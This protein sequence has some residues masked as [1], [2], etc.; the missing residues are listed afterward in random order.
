MATLDQYNHWRDRLIALLDKASKATTKISPKRADLYATL[1]DQLRQDS[2]KIQVVGTVKNGKSSFTNSIIGENVLPVDD[3]PCTA[4]VSEVKYSPEKKAV[5]HFCSPLPLGLLDEIPPQTRKY[6]ES[7]NMGRDAKGKTV[8]IPPLQV[9]YDH[10][11]DYVAIPEPTP[12]ILFNEDA[13]R[14]YKEKIDQESPYDV[15]ELFLPAPILKDGVEIVDSPGLNE[16]SK[17]TVVTLDYLKKADAAIFLWNATAPFTEKEKEVLEEVLLPLGF[18]DLIMVANKIDMVNNRERTT[19]YLQAQTQPYTSVKRLFPVSAKQ[20]LEALKTGDKALLKESGIPEFMDFLTDYLTRRKA[21]LKLNKTAKQVSNSLTTELLGQL[22]PSRIAT[23]NADSKALQ[24]RM[25]NAMPKLAEAKA[26]RT[27]ISNALDNSIPMALVPIREAISSFFKKL[28]TL[29][30]QWIR[31]FTPKTDIGLMAGKK[32]LQKVAT[33]IIEY[34]KTRVEKEYNVWNDSTLQPILAEQSKYVFGSLKEDV[35]EFAV[36]IETIEDIV[37][38]V[39]TDNI[40]GAN[41]LE[42]IAG[43]AGM[44]FL[45][46]GR[47][48]GDVFAGGF[49]FTNFLKNFAIDLGL[50]LGVGLVALW[51]WPP[52]GFI[53]SIAGMIVGMFQGKER[54]LSKLKTDISGY[55]VGE[56]KK[57]NTARVARIL[58]EVRETFE[59]IK[60]SVIKGLDT[61]IETV[62]NQLMEMER[63][64]RGEETA[65]DQKRRNLQM[66]NGELAAIVADIESL[67]T[68]VEKCC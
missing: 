50:S 62:D 59:N 40:E 47:A 43:I 42:R 29:I 11:S 33:E 52:L 34:T 15:A 65:I 14:D 36:E 61:E 35:D 54:K 51:I 27:Q 19:L 39:K 20:A 46:M 31:E 10:M 56:L 30:P 5:V 7:H 22:I 4:V 3:I 57:E 55:I 32:D 37:N 21:Q 24:D 49:D 66:L 64:C 53:A 9:P 44:L 38:G 1:R 67:T 48:G 28:E 12:D 16:S 17:R 23:L 68:E 13:F 63:V 58:G 41:A 8:Q 45:P 26:K 60:I 18:K 2:L 6:I 25:N